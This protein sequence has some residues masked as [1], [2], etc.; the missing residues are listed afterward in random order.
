M[1]IK[2]LTQRFGPL[3][4]AVRIQVTN[5]SIEELDAI[6]DRLVAATSLDEALGSH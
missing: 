6:G 1:I 4:D 5:C 2:L 3:T